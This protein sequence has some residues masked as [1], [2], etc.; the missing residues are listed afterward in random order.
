MRR[1]NAVFGVGLSGAPVVLLPLDRIRETQ[2]SSTVWEGD[3]ELYGF[4]TTPGRSPPNTPP[5][6][7]EAD[8]RIRLSHRPVS[9]AL[10]LLLDDIPT[11]SL[12]NNSRHGELANA[13]FVRRGGGLYRA[14][15]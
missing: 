9:R 11:K 1:L 12:R 15:S 10:L 5:V 14:T 2:D 4:P 6:R 7:A 3:R 13:S 8:G